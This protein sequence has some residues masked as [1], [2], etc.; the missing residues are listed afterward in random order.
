MYKSAANLHQSAVRYF[1][2]CS[3]VGVA[4]TLC[5]AS[6]AVCQ[7][8]FARS[9]ALQPTHVASAAEELYRSVLSYSLYDVGPGDVAQWRSSAQMEE[10]ADQGTGEAAGCCGESGWLS[11]NR[12]ADGLLV[13]TEG[14]GRDEEIQVVFHRT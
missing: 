11:S 8:R 14:P 13:A 4:H 3:A 1:W 9:R 10:Y 2:L 12:T 7:L 5:R 6:S